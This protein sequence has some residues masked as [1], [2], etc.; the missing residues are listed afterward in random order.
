[1]R[2]AHM[3]L[4]PV[5]L[6]GGA[7][8]RL[9][10][11][12]R[13]ER[14]K[15]FLRLTDEQLSLFQLTLQRVSGECF[16]P[17]LLVG[18]Q[19][20]E[21]LLRAQMQGYAAHKT[22]LL[23]EPLA[24]NTAPAIAMA[25]LW[26]QRQYGDA[27]RLLVLPSD[28]FM[29]SDAAFLQA[30]QAL[31]MQLPD[32]AFG[33]FGITP[34]RAE[35]GYGYLECEAAS[36][37]V[38]ARHLRAFSEKPTAALAEHY[39]VSGKHYC[40]SGVFLCPVR[41]LLS[42][43]EAHVP[44]LLRQAR[45]TLLQAQRGRDTLYLPQGPMEALPDISIDYA[46]MQQANRCLVQPLDCGWS[47]VGNWYGLWQALRQKPRYK[48]VRELRPWGHFE[49]IYNGKGFC[50]KRLLIQSGGQLSLQYHRHR[51]EYWTV[52]SGQ[53]QV[54]CDHE[55]KQLRRGESVYVP[56][57]ML[58]RIENLSAQPLEIIEI[59]TGDYLGEDDIVR[60]DDAYG[61]HAQLL[62]A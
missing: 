24:R 52:M 29:A 53:A 35:T 23:L 37:E 42:A 36:G 4:L 2:R 48:A 13:P 20:H 15:P 22:Q 28:H 59:Q 19:S 32:D 16:A 7:G 21:A 60:L 51:A 38:A 40:N 55:Q 17:P 34:Q 50:V 9:W 25:A 31:N 56:K 47:D 18:N 57:G 44:E 30:V 11:A 12:S 49:P 41:A 26:A 62:Y 6:C 45:F 14:P 3:Q 61:R 10:P 46:I 8:T 43:Y 58:H 54:Q 1:M 27:V 39:A 5:I 33:L